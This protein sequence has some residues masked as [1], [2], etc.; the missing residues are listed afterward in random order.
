MEIQI[1]KFSILLMCI[2]NIHKLLKWIG[3]Q[4]LAEAAT[5]DHWWKQWIVGPAFTHLNIDLYNN[6]SY[7]AK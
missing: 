3:M 7:S 5:R 6:A 2:T 4:W 1:F